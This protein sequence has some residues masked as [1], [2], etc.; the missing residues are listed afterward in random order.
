[1]SP[2]TE[3]P[4]VS[5]RFLDI[6]QR[7]EEK[8]GWEVQPV[9]LGD[10]VASCAHLPMSGEWSTGKLL[11]QMAGVPGPHSLHFALAGP[12]QPSLYLRMK[13]S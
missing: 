10:C 2:G 5:W 11:E 4:Q 9:G 13:S 8:R 3:I 7:Y 6:N 1:M 12:H